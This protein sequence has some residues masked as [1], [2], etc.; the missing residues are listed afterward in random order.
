MT[1]KSYTISNHI[2][3]KTKHNITDSSSQPIEHKSEGNIYRCVLE[4]TRKLCHVCGWTSGKYTSG[5]PVL[6]LHVLQSA[7]RLTCAMPK[8]K[9]DRTNLE[10]EDFVSMLLDA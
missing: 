8:H 5:N 6:Q 4:W 1:N 7:C 2:K 10:S 9:S 3:P